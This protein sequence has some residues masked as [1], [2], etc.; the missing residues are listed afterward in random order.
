MPDKNLQELWVLPVNSRVLAVI[1]KKFPLYTSDWLQNAYIKALSKY[2]ALKPHIDLLTKLVKNK[3]LNPCWQSKGVISVLKRSILEP[4]REKIIVGFYIPKLKKIFIVID[5]NTNWFLHYSNTLLIET[6]LHEFA[7]KFSVEKIA[8]FWATYKEDLAK[9][10]SY[11]FKSLFVIAEDKNIDEISLMYVKTLLI[12]MEQKKTKVK[13]FSQLFS[14]MSKYLNLIS[15]YSELSPEDSKKKAEGLYKTIQGLMTA[16]TNEQLIQRWKD[17]VSTIRH[18]YTAYSKMELQDVSSI[19]FQ[20]L[21]YPSEIICILSQ[22]GLLLDKWLKL[23]K[24][25]S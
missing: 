16:K 19:C 6:T 10:Y 13:T 23:I 24:K 1:D 18:L 5:N 25:F 11:F 14:R 8:S 17:N 9:F 22:G 20:E 4:R 12:I 15:K 7:H 2:P 3:V 21:F